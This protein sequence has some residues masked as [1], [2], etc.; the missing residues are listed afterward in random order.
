[1]ERCRP[2]LVFVLMF[3]LPGCAATSSLLCEPDVRPSSQ[4][5]QT[6]TVS[7]PASLLQACPDAAT[8]WLSLSKSQ[9]DASVAT[10]PVSQTRAVCGE[11]VCGGCTDGVEGCG[12]VSHRSSRSGLEGGFVRGQKNI[13]LDG[14]GWVMGIPSKILL[15]NSKVDS[16]D[17]S[18]EVERALRQYLAAN[19]L[20]D[21]KVRVNQYDPVGEWKRLLTNRAIH[22]AFKYT[23]GAWAVSKYTLIPG[24]LFGADEYNPFTQSISLY[25]DRASLALREG[26]HAKNAIESRYPGLWASSMYVPGS[27]MWVDT[28]STREVIRY[29]K[30]TG[31]RKLERE[32][33]L[34]L[35]PAFGSRL[36]SSATL[37]LDAGAGQAAQGSLAL[38]GHAVG[39]T[40]AFRVSDTPVDMVKSVYG[41]VKKPRPDDQPVADQPPEDN[42]PVAEKD[43]EPRPPQD[44]LPVHFVPVTLV[45]E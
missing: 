43:N 13:L 25:S 20:T 21:V 27:P 32:A 11:Q 3:L 15:W 6:Q 5:L 45:Y 35:F 29:T 31:N 1:M 10:T 18:P 33:Y 19:G 39:R 26:A 36:G 8:P 2:A 24:R 22:P 42:T 37:F 44:I 16:H 4:A 40:M 30:Q 7:R 38:V 17:V 12:R 41:I 28:L 14:T 9:S 34:V 23:V